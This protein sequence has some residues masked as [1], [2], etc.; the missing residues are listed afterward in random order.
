MMQSCL[1]VADL[2][3]SLRILFGLWR[4]LAGM[5]TYR[6]R[7]VAVW[8]SLG[9]PMGTSAAWGN[10]GDRASAAARKVPEV[11]GSVNG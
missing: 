1:H 9:G 5:S 8:D 2:F 10:P 11:L 3:V 7:H 6:G 4:D